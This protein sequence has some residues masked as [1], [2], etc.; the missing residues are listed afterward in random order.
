MPFWMRSCSFGDHNDSQRI[1]TAATRSLFLPRNVRHPRKQLKCRAT[2][3]EP[4]LQ[5]VARNWWRAVGV[6][7]RVLSVVLTS[8]KRQNPRAHARGSPGRVGS[9]LLQHVASRWRQPTGSF[10]RVNQC[11]T[12][13][14]R[15]LTHAARWDVLARGCCNLWRAVGVSQR[16]LSDVLT[17]VKRAEPACSRTRLAGTCWHAVTCW[18]A[19]TRWHVVTRC[20]AVVATGGVRRLTQRS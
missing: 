12:R 17:S 18:L 5:L 3:G 6:S 13:R 8:V 2:D 20:P 14:T 19:G 9:R 4:L 1:T 15:V 11:Q 16:V 7:Q 10:R